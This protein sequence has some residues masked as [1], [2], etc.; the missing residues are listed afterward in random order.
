MLGNIA[1][2]VLSTSSKWADQFR[3]RT[4]ERV[5][6]RQ[7]RGLSFLARLTSTT[8]HR[9]GWSTLVGPSQNLLC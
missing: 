7:L 3:M 4:I 5:E 1:S 6:K 2:V 9:P 8:Y